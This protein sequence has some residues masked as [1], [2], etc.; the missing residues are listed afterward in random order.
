M[1]KRTFSGTRQEAY[2]RNLLIAIGVA[3]IIHLI[4]GLMIR[5]FGDPNTRYHDKDKYRDEYVKLEL[6]EEPKPDRIEEE[7]KS[8]PIKSQPIS[9]QLWSI[10]EVSDAILKDID[11]EPDYNGRINPDNVM[12]QGSQVSQGRTESAKLI[13][14]STPNYP[15]LAKKMGIEGVVEVG[16]KVDKNGNPKEIVILKSSGSGI[17]DKEALRAAEKCKFIPAFNDGKK[18]EQKFKIEYRFVLEGEEII[19]SN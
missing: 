4:M 5:G 2:N 10:P 6:Y 9:T 18:T 13:K 12:V 16:F 14:Q 1:K 17:L 19:I 8:R 3:I 7:I 11:F 15:D